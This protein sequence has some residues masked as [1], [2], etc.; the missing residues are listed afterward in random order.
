MRNF[1]TGE[2][3]RILI[4]SLTIK[5]GALREGQSLSYTCYMVLRYINFVLSI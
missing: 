3:A 2:F 5:S 4:Q 1:T